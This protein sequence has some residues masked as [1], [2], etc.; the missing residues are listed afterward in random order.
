MKLKNILLLSLSVLLASGIFFIHK[1]KKITAP[2]PSTRIIECQTIKDVLNYA[3]TQDTLVIFDLDNTLVHPGIEL[4]S[5][6][7]FSYM[8]KQ[9]QAEGLDA[10]QALQ[11]VLKVYYHIHNFIDLCPVEDKVTLDTLE[12][13]HKKGINT[14]ALTSR[15]LPLIQRTQEQLDHAGIHFNCP[16]NFN[17]PIEITLKKSALAKN[18]IIFCNNNSKGQTLMA[19][20]KALNMHPT[21][22]VFVD[23]KQQYLVDVEHECIHSNIEFT[24]LRYGVL[25]NF[26]AQF[27]PKRAQ[28]QLNEL[29]KAHELAVV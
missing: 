7:W 23:D 18:G 27:D 3:N 20:L 24:G 12:L 25:D 11:N 8:I 26:V 17:H 13:L 15:S 22:I 19:V 21:A 16:A 2:Y 28:E 29:L 10:E 4:G 14:M 6:Q 1:S 5:D 9:K